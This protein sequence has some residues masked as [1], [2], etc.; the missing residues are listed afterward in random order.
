MDLQNALNIA[1][2]QNAEF[3][4]ES[5]RVEIKLPVTSGSSLVLFAVSIDSQR[6]TLSVRS[7]TNTNTKI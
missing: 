1:N 5:A 2:R 7:G 3:Q 6:P 4:S